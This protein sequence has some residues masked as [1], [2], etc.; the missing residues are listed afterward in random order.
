MSLTIEH[1][2]TELQQEVITLKARV[3]DQTGLAGAVRAI[4]NLATAPVRTH[5]PSLIGVKCFG[6]PKE[7]TDKEE[8]FQQCEK[9]RK[10]SVLE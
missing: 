6:R 7:F 10:R 3:A 8:D 9:R 2:V 4:N 1:A 5:A